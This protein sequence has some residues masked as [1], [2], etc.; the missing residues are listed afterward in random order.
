M[1]IITKDERKALQARFPR[2]CTHATKHH[3]Y[4]ELNTEAAEYLSWLRHGKP[5]QHKSN[6]RRGQKWYYA[7]WERGRRNA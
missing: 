4:A 2:L 6:A 1:I 7:P 5:K 3:L